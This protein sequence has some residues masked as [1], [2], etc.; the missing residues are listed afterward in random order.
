MPP[1]RLPSEVYPAQPTGTRP[2]GRPRTRWRDHVSRL[3][4]ERLGV[5]DEELE[6]VVRDSDVGASLLSILPPRPHVDQAV[7][8]M[9]G[10][11][12]ILLKIILFSSKIV[13]F[14]VNTLV[15]QAFQTSVT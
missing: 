10:S 13:Q 6:E 15:L 5:T 7:E 4:C 2:R 12:D 11:I 3:A 9:D 14:S 1:G 8:N